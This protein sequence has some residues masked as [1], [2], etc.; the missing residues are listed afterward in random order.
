MHQSQR[1]YSYSDSRR[2]RLH[3]PPLSPSFP[4]LSHYHSRHH[5]VDGRRDRDVCMGMSK[6]SYDCH[7]RG[8]RH[9]W[10]KMHPSQLYMDEPLLCQFVYEK[11]KGEEEER[12]QE[13]EQERECEEREK[14][15]ENS[16]KEEDDEHV[17][18]D[19][20]TT[21]VKV[22]E[23]D[24][25]KKQG[26]NENATMPDHDK[27]NTNMEDVKQEDSND[28]EIKKGYIYKFVG[29]CQMFW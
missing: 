2:Y 10:R 26:A 12:E 6:Y 21:L 19:T 16:K 27:E 29:Q 14:N 9:K 13:Q 5:S 11:D 23:N 25:I 4:S 24:A 7:E 15:L 8:Y 18:S 1:L 22:E 3:S 20:N 17:G 28:T